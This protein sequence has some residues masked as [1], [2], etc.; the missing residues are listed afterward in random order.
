[1]QA[2]TLNPDFTNAA[3]P[4]T[5]QQ[6]SALI[7]LLG[8]E[9]P[10]VYQ[11]VR[12]KIISMGSDT[13]LWL[14][15]CQVSSDATL[16]RHALEIVRHFDRELS[17]TRFMAYCLQDETLI[18]L[19]KG[20]LLMAQTAYPEINPAAYSAILDQLAG[21]LREWL[22][23][24][25]PQERMLVRVNQFLFEEKGFTGNMENYYDPENTFINRVL[26]RRTGNPVGLCM[27]Y[28]LL[29]QRLGFSVCGV[30]LPGHSVC[31]FLDGT[32]EVYVDA[33]NLGKLL[34]RH[35]C[36]EHLKRCKHELRDEYLEPMTARRML[37]RMCGNLEQ[38]YTEL[39][40]DA[41]ASRVQRYLFAL[42]R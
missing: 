35:D 34:T 17:D 31:R 30:G 37:A 4:A 7:K 19:E 40:R 1:M 41:D 5:D 14:K 38:I 21:E 9:D 20:A 33:F 11:A 10:T 28:V 12:N 39:K 27:I 2:T 8:D 22:A 3:P 36:I 16:R 6:R 15:P 24:S 25:D 32:E 26:D 23:A 42:T 13:Q 29:M 18:D